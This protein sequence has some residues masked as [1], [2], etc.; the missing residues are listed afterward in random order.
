MC[1][2]WWVHIALPVALMAEHF[3]IA[4][5]DDLEGDEAASLS[6]HLV[7]SGGSTNLEF[8]V[9]RILLADESQFAEI[10]L[11]AE[12]ESTFVVAVPASVWARRVNQRRLHS[13]GLLKPILCSIVAGR[14]T[15]RT[16]TEDAYSVKAWIGLLPKDQEALVEFGES[17]ESDF[18]FVDHEE[19]TRMP[20]AEALVTIAAEHFAF[21]SAESGLG[22]VHP[23]PGASKDV[24]KRLQTLEESLVSIQASLAALVPSKPE[25]AQGAKPVSILKANPKP[26]STKVKF[27][28]LDPGVVSAAL[29]AGVSEEHL[30]EMSQ[31]LTKNPS[32]MEDLPKTARAKKNTSELSE[33]DEEDEEEDAVPSDGSKGGS[34]GDG[35]VAK[36]L[37]KLT[38]VCSTLASQKAKS[39]GIEGM[40]DSA[41]A[42]G[43]A[44][45]SVSSRKHAVALRALKKCL[46]DNPQFL[47]QT[48]ESLLV[49]DFQS[50]PHLPGE[51]MG[52]CTTRGWLESRSRIQNY[53]AH[54]RWVWQVSGIWDALI[55]GEHHQARAR[56]ALLVAANVLASLQHARIR[57]GFVSDVLAK[58][59]NWQINSCGKV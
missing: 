16:R 32:R 29:S 8:S 26:K 38:K 43:S 20:H 34:S 45:G 59:M 2:S 31:V 1:S 24:D 6:S 5:V 35:M 56:C 36:A 39:Q 33:S 10:I 42:S 30:E 48:I 55:R 15:D 3:D 57:H 49:A 21:Q 46:Q 40:L 52:S 12:V 19:E 54:V 22:E 28:G 41:G 13:R 23:E 27:V 18:C 51:P 7:H 53:Q 25:Q 58:Q 9:G 50:K 44:E 11:I 14:F 37:V 17:L 47:Y 4:E